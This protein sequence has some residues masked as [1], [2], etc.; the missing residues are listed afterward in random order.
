[1]EVAALISTAIEAG[2]I[3]YD[4]IKNIKQKKESSKVTSSQNVIGE[5]STNLAGSISSVV[6][7]VGKITDG[8]RKN[9]TV[10]NEQ[11]N[12]LKGLQ[13]DTEEI[14]TQIKKAIKELGKDAPESLRTASEKLNKLGNYFKKLDSK[15]TENQSSNNQKPSANNQ[16]PVSNAIGENKID[17]MNSVAQVAVAD[18]LGKAGLTING[19]VTVIIGNPATNEMISR[20]VSPT[21]ID[22]FKNSLNSTE[23]DLQTPLIQEAATALKTNA[24][25][26]QKL[27]TN[28]KH[29]LSEMAQN[30]SNQKSQIAS[31]SKVQKKNDNELNN[32]V[33]TEAPVMQ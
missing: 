13:A 26:N 1:M 27:A 12:E 16:N 3:A 9:T 18:A 24:P 6:G 29:E 7:A 19:N 8:R 23:N 11:F 4:I 31:E 21:K 25:S 30:E 2:K 5:A 14:K 32:E 10:T 28:L 33:E 20:G 22:E 17:A 15:K